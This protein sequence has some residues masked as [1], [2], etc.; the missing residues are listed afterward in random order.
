[1]DMSGKFG[2]SQL[3]FYKK[4]ELEANWSR[5]LRSSYRSAHCKI[6]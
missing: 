3:R 4:Q 5:D 6:P 1:M 2:H